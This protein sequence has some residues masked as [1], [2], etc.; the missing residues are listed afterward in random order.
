MTA[1]SDLTSA[2]IPPRDIIRGVKY[3]PHLTPPIRNA[4]WL[5]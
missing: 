4:E 5:L 1:M 3:L 2:L